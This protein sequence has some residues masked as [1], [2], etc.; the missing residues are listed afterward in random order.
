M[1]CA[2]VSAFPEKEMRICGPNPLLRV[3]AGAAESS[4]AAV[5]YIQKSAIVIDEQLERAGVRLAV[6]LNRCCAR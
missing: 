5:A 4:R 6:I 1:L 2:S 3:G